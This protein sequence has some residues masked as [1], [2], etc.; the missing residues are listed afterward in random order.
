MSFRTTRDFLLHD[1]LAV[2]T[3]T[4]RARFVDHNRES[5]D[6]VLDTCDQV[7]WNLLGCRFDLS[8]VAQRWHELLSNE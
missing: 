8:L 2:N 5:F 1:W 7:L 6:A 3:L 4:Q